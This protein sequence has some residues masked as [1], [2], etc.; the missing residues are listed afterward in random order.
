MKISIFVFIYL[1]TVLVFFGYFIESNSLYTHRLF[2][3]LFRVSS[4]RQKQHQH[5]KQVY[6]YKF[7]LQLLIII[8]RNGGVF[9]F[10]PHFSDS[11][12]IMIASELMVDCN[13]RELSMR[14]QKKK[15]TEAWS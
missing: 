8:H 12:I 1:E 13:T 9:M 7:R 10:N 14:V 11:W 4:K 15:I 5:N 2:G 6:E 3:F